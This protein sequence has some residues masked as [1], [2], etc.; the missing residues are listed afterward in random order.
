[1]LFVWAISQICSQSKQ[2][3]STGCYS[4]THF[5]KKWQSYSFKANVTVD[6]KNSKNRK[7]LVFAEQLTN[8]GLPKRPVKI[9]QAPCFF[10]Y[11]KHLQVQNVVGILNEVHGIAKYCFFP[12]HITKSAYG[13]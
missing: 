12:A 6:V 13:N 4:V 9:V 2:L 5:I 1:M 10:Q 8:Y 11:H 3:N 7:C